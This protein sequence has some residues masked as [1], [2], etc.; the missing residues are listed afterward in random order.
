MVSLMSHQEI[1]ILGEKIG[2]FCN[3]LGLWLGGFSPKMVHIDEV[4]IIYVP[5]LNEGVIGPLPQL[6]SEINLGYGQLESHS[7]CF[8]HTLHW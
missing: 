8:Q 6:I 5:E 3:E 2:V 1:E 7:S 4:V